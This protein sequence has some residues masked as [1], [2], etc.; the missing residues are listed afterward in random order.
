MPYGNERVHYSTS[1]A[2]NKF[3]AAH[4]STIDNMMKVS[5]QSMAYRQRDAPHEPCTRIEIGASRG[6]P[7]SGWLNSSLQQTLQPRNRRQTINSVAER[8]ACTRTSPQNKTGRSRRCAG[9]AKFRCM[10]FSCKDGIDVVP[11]L[12]RGLWDVETCLRESGIPHDGSSRP[13]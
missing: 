13:A 9:S 3:T 5:C 4:T 6:S 8:A 7:T 1:T 12:G 11:P 2:S 10:W